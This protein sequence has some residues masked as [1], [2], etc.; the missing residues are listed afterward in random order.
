M[1]PK[2]RADEEYDDFME[3]CME[4]GGSEEECELQWESEASARAGASVKQRRHLQAFYHTPWAILPAKLAEIRAALDSDQAWARLLKARLADSRDPAIS[5]S[6]RVMVLP[7]YG[8]ICQRSDWWGDVS[9]EAIG[10]AL[11]RCVA[12]KSC[13]AVVMTFDSPGGSIFGVSELADKIYKARQEK[14]IVGI[15]DPMAAS[16]A[17]WLLSQCSEINC[18]PSGMVGSIGCL[19]AHEDL[20]ALLEQCG[21]KVTLITA[22]KYKAEQDPSRELTDEARAAMQEMVDTY[23]AQFVAAVARGRGVSEAAVRAGYGQGRVYTAQKALG[24]GMV[25]RVCTMDQCLAAL[26]VAGGGGP[27]AQDLRRKLEL[28][29]L[30]E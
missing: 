10:A 18:A 24:A 21:V 16:A 26:G 20:T 2:P 28:A 7:V 22:G 15:A 13:K 4:D 17:Y 11:D 3:R 5:I 6:G 27:T 12:D 8:T 14:P 23:Y 25:D 30:D 29:E 19:T 9:C 1:V